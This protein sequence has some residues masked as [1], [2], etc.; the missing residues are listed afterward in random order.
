MES[1]DFMSGHAAILGRTLC[2]AG[3]NFSRTLTQLDTLWPD[4]VR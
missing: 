1:E 2:L 4:I 3:N